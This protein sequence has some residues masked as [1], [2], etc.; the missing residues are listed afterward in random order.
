MNLVVCLFFIYFIFIY[1]I[2][3]CFFCEQ[4]QLQ[5]ILSPKI[6]EC[7]SVTQVICQALAAAQSVISQVMILQ[8]LLSPCLYYLKMNLASKSTYLA[9]TLHKSLLQDGGVVQGWTQ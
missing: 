8:A 3:V 1:V 2:F 7:C 6:K 4:E 5:C 9:V